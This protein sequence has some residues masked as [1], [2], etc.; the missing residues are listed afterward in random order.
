MRTLVAVLLAT[1]MQAGAADKHHLSRVYI[2]TAESP[3]GTV[4]E[5]EQGRRDSVRDL[6][7]AM[8][9]KKGIT[10]VDNR[11]SADVV[12]EV[13]GR[14]KREGPSGG[15][16]GASVT[17]FGDTIVRVRVKAGDAETEIK[18]I[19]Q[20]YWGRAAKDAADRLMKWIVR[21]STRS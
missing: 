16:G 20:A 5:E 3:S 10:V 7:E 18:G 14:E 6:R 1:V 4:T 15:F 19:G 8:D 2:Y 17:E 21:Q 12:V 13:T 9:R 11:E